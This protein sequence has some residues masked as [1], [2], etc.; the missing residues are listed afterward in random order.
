MHHT[1][2]SSRVIISLSIHD[3]EALFDDYCSHRGRQS[4]EN[5][6]DNVL[7]FADHT[8]VCALAARVLDLLALAWRPVFE[9][10]TDIDPWEVDGFH[11]DPL[12]ELVRRFDVATATLEV[13]GR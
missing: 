3:A 1:F 10:V 5:A 6:V 13:V 12:P 11:P 7:A 2:D 9:Q 8:R 4:R